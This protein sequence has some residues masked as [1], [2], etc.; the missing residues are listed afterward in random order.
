MPSQADIE[1]TDK[2]MESGK[3]LGIPIIDHIIIGYNNFYSFYDK[4]RIDIND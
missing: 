2:L 1:L 3:L 4:K